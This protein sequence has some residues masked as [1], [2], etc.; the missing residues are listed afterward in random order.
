MSTSRTSFLPLLVCTL[1]AV[2][3]L[4]TGC[5]PDRPPPGG[6]GGGPLPPGGNPNGNGDGGTS[7]GGVL[8][9]RSDGS[10][11]PAKPSCASGA[12]CAGPCPDGGVICAGNNCGF[13][14]PVTLPFAGDPKDIALGDVDEDGDDD[15]VTAN[16]DGKSVAVLLNRGNGVF[17]TPSLWTAG[18]EPT[19]L[20]LEDLNGDGSLDL[21][22]AN[23]G[24]SSVGVYRGK[25]NGD[26]L[27]PVTVGALGLNL[28]DLV[29]GRFNGTARSVALLRG[30][31][32]VVSVFP[33]KSD[34]T[35]Q[36]SADYASSLG[37]HALVAE[38]FNGDGRLDLAL[39]HE[40]DCGMSSSTPCQSVG[41]LLGKADG[42]FQEQLLTSTGGTPRGLVAAKLDTDTVTDL[43]V[44]DA[45][46]NQVLMLR[47]QSN[48][49][50]Y[51]PVAYPVVKAPS[52][53]VLA[54]INRDTLPDVLVTSATGNQVGLLL[55]QSGGTFS[56]QV[57]LT[58][59]PQDV[60][61]QGLLVSDFDSDNVRDMAVLTRS[62]IQL[63]WGI[64]R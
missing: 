23:S 9:I 11:F 15:L 43:L 10:N 55:G 16:N 57:P 29:V 59:W 51:E 13:V 32:Q 3:V 28:N 7:D 37:A 1:S 42:T 30:S 46:R 14:A 56:P 8:V 61:L 6:G 24:D 17:Q 33:V 60:G 40:T 49:R 48:G 38:D 44:A 25:G 4:S 63:L 20:A 35:L 12:S 52:R 27:A 34:G 64:C 58:A 22:V 18:K 62:G 5:E 53:L 47:G 21:L 19:A 45:S 54:D 36:T 50:F 39:T 2:L 41:V 31:E 26:F